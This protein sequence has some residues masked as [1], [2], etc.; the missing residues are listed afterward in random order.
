MLGKFASTIGSAFSRNF[1]RGTT[2]TP[3]RSTGL[4]G[5]HM[6]SI[7][8]GTM[9]LLGSTSLIVKNRRRQNDNLNRS[10]NRRPF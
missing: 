2:M 10:K 3:N 1:G 8:L 6:L 5:K 7:G 9:G 4:D